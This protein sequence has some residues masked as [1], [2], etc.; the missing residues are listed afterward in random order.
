MV[1]ISRKTYERNGIETI[2]DND[3]ILWLNEKHIEERLGHKNLQEITTKYSDHRKH[4]YEL[5][6]EPKKQCN[7]I[8]IDKKLTVKVIMDCRTT[9]AQ[10][11]RTRLGFK[12][13]DV[14]LMKEQ[15]VLTKIMS[16]F[17]GENMQTQ[18]NNVL[19]VL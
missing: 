15:S 2:V 1:D 3:G 13:Y 17:E 19:K 7:R 16:S 8:F 9:S 12:Q 5:V 4:R 18:Y 6:E 14:I 10:K 11:F